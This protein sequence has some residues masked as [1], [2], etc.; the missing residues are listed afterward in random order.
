VDLIKIHVFSNSPL[1]HIIQYGHFFCCKTCGLHFYLDSTLFS[2]FNY[3]Y[4][5]NFSPW[6]AFCLTNNAI[7]IKTRPWCSGKKL[8]F[9]WPNYVIGGARRPSLWGDVLG[10]QPPKRRVLTMY[11][12]RGGRVLGIL[13]TDSWLMQRHA[14]IGFI[15]IQRG[16]EYR[17]EACN[18]QC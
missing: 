3:F 1:I 18:T 11:M 6:I 8:R 17:T 10:F 5:N 4:Q 12:G 16:P 9:T 13:T 14:S 2:K 7:K 15:P